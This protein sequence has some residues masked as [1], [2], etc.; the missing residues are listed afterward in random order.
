[1]PK[2]AA[3]T[4]GKVAMVAQTGGRNESGNGESS[5][6]SVIHARRTAPE[7]IIL[8]PAAGARDYPSARFINGEFRAQ[9]F[10]DEALLYALAE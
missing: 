6:Y 8:Q 1:M 2:R 7:K 9:T 4:V 10:S 3:G 5:P